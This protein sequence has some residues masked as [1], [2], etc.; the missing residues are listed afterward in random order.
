MRLW[1]LQVLLTQ[2][3]LFPFLLFSS[4]SLSFLYT[5]QSLSIFL[6]RMFPPVR[7]R[8]MDDGGCVAN[9]DPLLF[10]LGEALD[11]FCQV[12]QTEIVKL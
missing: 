3:S 8:D 5:C 7:S 2:P 1:A 4:S 11:H 12:V 6:L 10:L 9:A